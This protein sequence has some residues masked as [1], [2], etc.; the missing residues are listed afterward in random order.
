MIDV[1][2]AEEGETVNVKIIEVKKNCA[3]GEKVG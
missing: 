2:G 3:T 1:P